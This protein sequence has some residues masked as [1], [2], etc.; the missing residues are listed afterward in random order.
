M[1]I[2]CGR[3][4]FISALLLVEA[5]VL[6]CSA[7]D[8]S[9]DGV[10]VGASDQTS[11]PR[12][13]SGTPA[14]ASQTTCASAKMAA[15]FADIDL[16]VMLDRS[17]SMG[18]TTENASFDPALRWIPATDALKSFFTT[19][20]A[21]MRASLSF[22]PDGGDACSADAYAT[23]AQ[24]IAALPS[25]AL[26]T[27]VG[28][29]RPAGDTPTLSAVSGA[30]AQADVLAAARPDAR[31]AVVLVTDGEP[32]G[33]GV[34]AATTKAEVGRVAALVSAAAD[35]HP[36]FVIGVGPSVDSL[37]AIASAGRT[38]A[39]HVPVDSP[40]TTRSAIGEALA[41]VRHS[42]A[43]TLNLP[44]SPTGQQLDLTSAEVLVSSGTPRTLPFD[45]SCKDGQ[46][47]RFATGRGSRRIELCPRD[48]DDLRN[49][50]AKVEIR[51]QCLPPAPR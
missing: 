27:A 39:L 28:K 23:P 10:E 47:W 33:C 30:L 49:A 16:V 24:P 32:Y 5:S 9:G 15:T 19:P 41:T 36:T 31:V 29:M 35:R 1:S 34:D 40:E 2:S 3:I 12:L 4:G 25:S 6:G 45:A 50:A 46:G 8:A 43:C 11:T 44:E 18:D 14:A 26:A 22:F 13:G 51:F 17:G 42:I 7:A 38:K 48:C 37:D 21:G 20:S